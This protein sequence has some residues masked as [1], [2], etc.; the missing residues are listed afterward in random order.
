MN[1]NPAV[2]IIDS[3][4]SFRGYDATNPII[5]NLNNTTIPIT[6][7]NTTIFGNISNIDSNQTIN[8]GSI[9]SSSW[10]PSS[11]VEFNTIG[12]SVANVR[13]AGTWTG[14]L[15]FEATLDDV[16]WSTINVTTPGV[17]YISPIYYASTPGWW[18]I[19]VAGYSKIRVRAPGVVVASVNSI[20]VYY[21]GTTSPSTVTISEPARIQGM[22]NS[23]YAPL[24]SPV[25]IGGVGNGKVRT[26]AVNNYG[27]VASLNAG[28]AI[29]SGLVDGKT[30]NIWGS[31]IT[32]ATTEFAVKN[33]TYTE[34]TTS[35]QRSLVSTSILDTA[36]GTGAKI[37]R[38]TYFSFIS[39]SINGPYTEDIT[40][41]GITAV[42][43]IATNIC[44]IE[45]MEVIQAGSGGVNA[46]II[47]I[48]TT[49]LGLGNTIASIGVGARQ[50]LYAHHYV[51]TGVTAYIKSVYGSSTAT[52]AN[53]PNFQVRYKDYTIAS[54]TERILFDN[55]NIQGSTGTKQI[56]FNTP[57]SVVGP[58]VINF[59]VIPENGASQINRI[60]A[61]YFEV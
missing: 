9:I 32:N 18:K 5:V 24:G 4:G 14:N 37:V 7:S 61:D 38:L 59:Y 28:E 45:N 1:Y 42:N 41:N 31:V 13:I 40:M 23:G 56:N 29:K 30:G 60:A 54:P 34:Q 35:L 3:T 36:L 22:K 49:T 27:M 16:Y 2:V 48:K 43:T 21:R 55:I 44:F 15:S 25:V 12:L 57:H 53:V 46:G 51:P 17:N 33:T 6:N 19:D 20:S 10:T 39:G 47:S 11:Y 50:T 8:Y 52:S 26:L 58:A